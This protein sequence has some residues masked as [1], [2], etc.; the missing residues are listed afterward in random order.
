MAPKQLIRDLLMHPRA[1]DVDLES[2]EATEL[3]AA[4]IREKPFLRALYDRFYD[5]FVRAHEAAPEG[6]RL[7]VGA[8][9]GF[10]D[11]LIPGLLTIDLRPAAKVSLMASALELPL[12]QDSTGAIFMLNVLHHLPDPARFFEEATRVLAPGGRVV[13]TEPFVSPLSRLMFRSLH[14]EPFEPEQDDWQTPVDGALAG[15]NGAIPW[16]VFVRDRH[17]FEARFPSLE[18]RRVEPHTILLYLLSGGVSMRSLVPGLAFEPLAAVE[19]ILPE[20]W[21]E[22]LCT[23]MTVELVK[24]KVK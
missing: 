15:A 4:L 21:K 11:E 22:Q 1:R 14:H 5:D 13:I 9:G 7:E 3:H 20:S 18:I 24:K 12:G 2:A 8:G 6:A 10:L 19:Q 17:E 16:M 23:L